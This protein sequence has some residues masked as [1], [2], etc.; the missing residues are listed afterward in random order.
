MTAADLLA[1]LATA[2]VDVWAD[3]GRLFWEAP[4]GVVTDEIFARLRDQR[5]ELLAAVQAKAVE[6]PASK[7]PFPLLGRCPYHIDPADWRD[8]P[9]AG[10]VC[11][12]CKRCGTFI[13]YRPAAAA[14]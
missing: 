4:A 7:R 12:T 13:G 6:T 9:A 10:L 2:G 3:E 8:E 14:V 11:T 1:E 5:A